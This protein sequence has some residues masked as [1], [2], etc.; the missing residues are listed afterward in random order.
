MAVR[1]DRETS[2]APDDDERYLTLSRQPLHILLFLLPLIIGYE[3]CLALVLPTQDGLHVNTVE[4][5]RTLLQFFSVFGLGPTNGLYLGGLVIVLVLLV[6][7]VLAGASWRPR[8]IVLAGMAGETAVYVLPLLIVA[9][10][11]SGWTPAAGTAPPALAEFSLVSLM[12]ISIGAGL[13]EELVFRMIGMAILHTLIVDLGKASEWVG[14]GV[15]IA[16]TAAAFTWY[17]DLRGPDGSVSSRK[18]IFFLV[19]GT[20]FGLIYALRGFG[21]VVGV[22]ALYDIVTVI[23]WE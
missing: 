3:L 11:I 12:A 20:Y 4:A 13:Y 17:H 19:A 15:A 1:S 22:H 16:V 8:L 6:W 2:L 7:H 5:H 23:G 18:I 21:L 10:L 14:T 9:Q